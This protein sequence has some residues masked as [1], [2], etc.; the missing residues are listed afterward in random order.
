MT[1]TAT[2]HELVD[3]TR[4]KTL[5]NDDAK[6]NSIGQVNRR[7]SSRNKA[8]SETAVNEISH[9]L[10]YYHSNISLPTRP[11]SGALTEYQGQLPNWCRNK[12]IIRH[13]VT[14]SDTLCGLA[15]HY[16]ASVTNIGALNRFDSSNEMLLHA[17]QSVLVAVSQEW[18]DGATLSSPRSSPTLNSSLENSENLYGMRLSRQSSRTMLDEIEQD[19]K[20]ALVTFSDYYAQYDEIKTMPS[21]NAIKREHNQRMLKSP[22]TDKIKIFFQTVERSENGPTY[23][24]RSRRRE[25][26]ALD[27][28]KD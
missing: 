26:A 8:L 24:L 21:M 2:Y 19:L 4:C 5:K 11:T 1:P 27:S 12:L 7:H 14:K 18:L 25:T 13:K 3:L 16:D 10:N 15:L 28:F 23:A 20:V 9:T 6:E 17:F 22:V